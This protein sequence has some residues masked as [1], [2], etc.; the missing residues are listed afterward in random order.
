MT[1]WTHDFTL[2]I[3]APADRIFRALTTPS[4][5]ATWFAEHVEMEPRVGGPFRFWGK[6]TVGAPS[7]AEADGKV[8]AFTPGRSIGF[9]WRVLGVP[10]TVTLTVVPDENGARVAVKHELS[11]PLDQPRPKEL[12]D[13]WWRFA[14]GNLMVYTMEHGAVMRPDFADSHPEIRVVTYVKAP[15]STVFRA[16]IDPALLRQW[17]GA[18]EHAA[19]DA[20]E[21]GTWDLGWRYK[22]DGKEV[23]PPPHRILEFVENERFT[24]EWPDW[25]GDVSMPKQRVTWQLAPDG[26]GTTVSLIHAG[27]TRTVDLSDYP[28]GWG[29]FNSE[30]GRVAAT[31]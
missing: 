17:M 7:E 8:I 20:R 15:P 31:L 9:T 6:H 11:G 23:A 29:H 5:L 19:V 25:R 24:I 3:M 16:L 21:G 22:V 13:D 4:E 10:S 26:D 12:I 30:L 27:F 28:F 1:A 2:P 18:T 14:T